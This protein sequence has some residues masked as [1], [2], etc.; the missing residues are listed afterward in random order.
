MDIP[1]VPPAEAKTLLD[2]HGYVYVDVRS[3]PEFEAGH[4]AGAYNIPL[5]HQTPAGMQPN[6]KF[7]AV[8]E[9]TFPKDAKIVLGCRSGAR[10]LKA[11]GLLRH[12]GYTVIV[13]Q[14]C[15]WAGAPDAFGKTEPGWHASGL[16][17]S[18]TAE[19]GHA[20]AELETRAG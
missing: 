20:W 17:T 4:P 13:D 19:P 2:E 6:P 9:A 14:R 11:A 16:P 10:S 1:R 7:L 18:L 8:F 12:A 15:G 5:N 3:V